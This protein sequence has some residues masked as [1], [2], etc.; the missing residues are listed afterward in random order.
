MD[1]VNVPLI[2]VARA[3]WLDAE[4][5]GCPGVYWVSGGKR[6][7]LV[8]VLKDECDCVQR[9]LGRFCKHL[10]R[11]YL[12]EGNAFLLSKLRWFIPHPRKLRRGMKIAA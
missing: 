3:I 5:T 4:P 6:P 9:Q 7:H 11:A 2:T 10:T 1:A 8:S 12:A